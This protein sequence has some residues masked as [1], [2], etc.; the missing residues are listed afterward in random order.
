MSWAATLAGKVLWM[1]SMNAPSCARTVKVT[2]LRGAILA[3]LLLA[4]T[5]APAHAMGHAGGHSG[6]H[7]G[8]GSFHGHHEGFHHHGFHSFVGVGGVR[9]LVP[10]RLPLPVSVSLRLSLRVPATR[11]S[12]AAAARGRAGA[13][14]A[15]SR[16]PDREVR[17]PR[18][19]DQLSLAVGLDPGATTTASPASAVDPLSEQFRPRG[20]LLT[21]SCGRTS[22][23]S[24]HWHAESAAKLHPKLGR[25][26][27]EHTVTI[28]DPPTDPAPGTQLPL[29]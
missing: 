4:A 16:L 15:R 3:G 7:H 29:T 19:R 2:L 21:C 23:F 20:W 26:G 5:A 1:L 28:E 22:E 12:G 27:T 8:G 14:P 24:Q 10:V 9:P 18:R 11:G 17:A 25:S 6:G 13:D